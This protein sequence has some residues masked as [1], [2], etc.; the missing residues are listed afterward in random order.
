MLY[1][2]GTDDKDADGDDKGDDNDGDGGAGKFDEDGD[3]EGEGEGMFEDNDLRLRHV[4]IRVQSTTLKDNFFRPEKKVTFI[5]ILAL[6]RI[7]LRSEGQLRSCVL[8][9]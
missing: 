7:L 9:S 1:D 4:S 8:L 3:E 6:I 5:L 2:G